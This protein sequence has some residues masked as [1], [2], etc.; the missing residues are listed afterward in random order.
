MKE[1]FGE[2][3]IHDGELNESV[4]FNYVNTLIFHFNDYSISIDQIYNLSVCPNEEIVIELAFFNQN[5]YNAWVNDYVIND[6]EERGG[7]YDFRDLGNEKEYSTTYKNYRFKSYSGSRDNNS[8]WIYVLE[9]VK[10]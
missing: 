1:H 4:V 6:L 7:C 2:F 10:K 5:L 3:K 9:P 8:H